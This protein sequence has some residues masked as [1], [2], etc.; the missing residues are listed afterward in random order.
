MASAQ[1][2]AVNAI[3][4]SNLPPALKQQ[5]FDNL[6]AENFTTRTTNQGE[7]AEAFKQGQAK[8]LVGQRFI[9]AS[10]SGIRMQFAWDAKNMRTTFY[11]LGN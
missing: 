10:P 2:N 8:G 3:R 6:N 4:E 11:P 5:A 1:Q 7:V 9:E